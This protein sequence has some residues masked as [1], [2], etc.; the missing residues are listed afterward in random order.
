MFELFE[1]RLS[2]VGDMGSLKER[3]S[4]RWFASNSAQVEA[5]GLYLDGDVLG[6]L[7]MNSTGL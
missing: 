4:L 2:C 3:S 5:V 7:V 1:G 6:E